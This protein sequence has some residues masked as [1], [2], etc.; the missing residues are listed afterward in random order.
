MQNLALSF[1][2]QLKLLLMW[3]AMMYNKKHA[4]YNLF[5]LHF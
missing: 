1:R 3:T 2:E 5:S 4:I